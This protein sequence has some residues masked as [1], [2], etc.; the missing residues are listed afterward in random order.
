MI[1]NLQNHLRDKIE[2]TEAKLQELDYKAEE[3]R[4]EVIYKAIEIFSGSANGIESKQIIENEL[5]GLVKT[6]K[7]TVKN[8]DLEHQQLE[9]LKSFEIELKSDPERVKTCDADIELIFRN[10]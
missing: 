3:Q 5:P 6:Y 4:A 1:T 7:E 10:N 9:K 2:Q 8:A